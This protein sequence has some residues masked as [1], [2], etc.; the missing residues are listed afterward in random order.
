MSFGCKNLHAFTHSR[1][2]GLKEK[3]P[4]LPSSG[5]DYQYGFWIPILL[6]GTH[7]TSGYHSSSK[8]YQSAIP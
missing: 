4:S 2:T 7:I 1:L 6:D 5:K 8:F 3:C